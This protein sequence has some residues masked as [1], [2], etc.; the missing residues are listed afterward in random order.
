MTGFGTPNV[1]GLIGDVKAVAPAVAASEGTTGVGPDAGNAG[2]AAPKCAD[3]T[4]PVSRYRGKRV[5]GRRRVSLQGTSKDKGCGPGG[6]GAVRKVGVS[7][8][9]TG[10]HGCSFMN[11]KGRLTKARSC[12]RAI[13]LPAKGHASWRFTMRVHLPP[14]NYRVVARGFDTAGNKERPHKHTNTLKLRVR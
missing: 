3:R 8:A 9:R 11:A 1:T 13:L 2:S 10:R 4:A 6:R 12:R 7:I 5:V 14:G